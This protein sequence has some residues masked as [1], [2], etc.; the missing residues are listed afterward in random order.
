V[1][2]PDGAFFSFKRTAKTDNITVPGTPA[3]DPI[4]Q[5]GFCSLPNIQQHQMPVSN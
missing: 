5:G 4:A 3:Q 1:L 2:P